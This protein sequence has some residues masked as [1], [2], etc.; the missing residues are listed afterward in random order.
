M[1]QTT[2]PSSLS[3]N[4]YYGYDIVQSNVCCLHNWTLFCKN[5]YIFKIQ[6]AINNN[7][8]WL[9]VVLHPFIYKY[10]ISECTLS[11]RVCD[12]MMVS[13]T[14][15]L[16]SSQT[17]FATRNNK[18]HVSFWLLGERCLLE[19]I[20]LKQRSFYWWEQTLGIG[21]QECSAPDWLGLCDMPVG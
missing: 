19:W 12:S 18:R 7:L 1:H 16:K 8:N 11:N 2:S 15:R 9:S 3:F 4:Q 5:M 13:N 6:Y 21:T 14:I 17:Q 10:P 20:L